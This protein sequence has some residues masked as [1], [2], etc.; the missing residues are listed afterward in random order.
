M[1]VVKYVALFLLCGWMFFLGLLVGRGTAPITFDTEGFQKRLGLMAR[2]Q[3]EN[4]DT[5]AK[6]DLD[7]YEVL[8]KPVQIWQPGFNQAG[9]D[10][11]GFDPAGEILP[12]KADSSEGD[13]LSPDGV[14]IIKSRKAMTFKAKAVA[15]HEREARRSP[16]GEK[17]EGYT[18]QIAAY[19][20]LADAVQQMKKL[21][22]K[23]V[24]SYR[25]MGKTGNTIWH[26]VRAGSF[27][28][29]KSAERAL[30]KLKKARIKG[31]IIEKE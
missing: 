13:D 15:R 2:E 6:L 5:T 28:S 8:R 10:Q 22:S 3:E 4:R 7:F 12:E 24:A 30:Q 20:S 27:E 29:R 11:T 21:K 17:K 9:S 19:K 25:T 14:P 23:G 26:R 18:I 31:M 16:E 1:G